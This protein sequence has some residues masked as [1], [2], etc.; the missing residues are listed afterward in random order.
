MN[1]FEFI[2][3]IIKAILDLFMGKPK[4]DSKEKE[5][6]VRKEELEGKLKEIEEEEENLEVEELT[7]EQEL[8][9]WKGEE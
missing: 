3:D 1:I 2:K 8:D 7:P 4:K 6:E 5:L 9:Y